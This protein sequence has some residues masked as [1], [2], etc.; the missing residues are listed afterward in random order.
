MIQGAHGLSAIEAIRFDGIA[1]GIGVNVEFAGNGADFPVLGVKVS[2]NLHAR[3]RTDHV[4]SSS[5]SRVSWE[6]ID[7][8]ALPSA[9]DAAQKRDRRPLRQ[10]PVHD[11][12]V[13]I[14]LKLSAWRFR[15]PTTA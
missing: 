15:R 1:N 8:P 3:F 14:G 10:A 9:N 2:A 6:G 4:F 7:E 13:R 12:G 11:G 5:T